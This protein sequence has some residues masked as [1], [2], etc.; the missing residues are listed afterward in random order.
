VGSAACSA[1]RRTPRD[2]SLWIRRIRS[3]G[4]ASDLRPS[5]HES[6]P[7]R[8]AASRRSPERASSALAG[9]T[10]AC[11]SSESS[12]AIGST[13]PSRR[14]THGW[15]QRRARGASSSSRGDVRRRA[16]ATA[17]VAPCEFEREQFVRDDAP[18]CGGASSGGSA[19]GVIAGLRTGVNHHLGDASEHRTPRAGLIHSE[20]HVTERRRAPVRATSV[21][22]AHVGG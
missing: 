7:A 6:R 9:V 18:C 1:H 15:S 3:R 2:G 17:M 13:C 8:P 20:I 19:R 5:A 12:A 10:P 11:A 4:P 16:S 14:S 22:T 21:Q